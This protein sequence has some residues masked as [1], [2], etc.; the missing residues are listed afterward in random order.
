MGRSCRVLFAERSGELATECPAEHY[1][2]FAEDRSAGRSCQVLFAEH[3]G[4]VA[5]ERSAERSCQVLFILC[6]GTGQVPGWPH[7]EK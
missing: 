4:G 2:K 5:A 6:E 7:G 3:Y 1:E